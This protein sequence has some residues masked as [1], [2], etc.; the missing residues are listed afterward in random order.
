MAIRYFPVQGGAQYTNDYG[1]PRSGGRRH[2]GNDLFAP[3]GTP[4]LAV[5]DGSIEFKV[6]PTGGNSVYLRATD[7]TTYYYTH[8]LRYYGGNRSV[9][10]GEAIGEVGRTG[11]AAGTPPQLHFEVHPGGRRE[12]VNPF[13]LLTTAPTRVSTRGATAGRSIV[14]P[15]LVATAVGL[16]TWALLQPTEVRRLWDRLPRLA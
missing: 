16:G 9:K 12:T 14:V 7:G 10:A 4:L 15:L 5:D 2:Q 13:P 11:N 8:L 3:E 6:D 1:Q